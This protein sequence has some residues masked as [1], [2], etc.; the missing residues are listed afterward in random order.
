VREPAHILM[1]VETHN[2]PTGICPAPGAMTGAGG[3]IRDEAAVGKGSKPKA[4]LTG[5]TT[6]HLRIPGAEV[7]VW[8]EAHTCRGWPG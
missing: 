1:K 8:G 7:R 5:F 2:H 3:E 6:S 4:G